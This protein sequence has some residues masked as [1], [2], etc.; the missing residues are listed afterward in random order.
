MYVPISIILP[1]TIGEDSGCESCPSSDIIT[2]IDRPAVIE[3]IGFV[4]RNGGRITVI[5]ISWKSTFKIHTVTDFF[6]LF[7]H[8]L[9]VQQKIIWSQNHV[10]A[11][12]SQF[13]WNISVYLSVAY[14]C[15][16]YQMGYSHDQNHKRWNFRYD[17]C[18]GIITMEGWLK[19]A[20][21]TLSAITAKLGI[22]P[23]A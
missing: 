17:L 10:F 5:S 18:T 6:F 7:E 8:E 22:I 3:R 19:L 9:S 16:K 13:I 12:T 15:E 20:T 2:C 11:Q 1:E 14:Y 4:E 21:R 23:Y